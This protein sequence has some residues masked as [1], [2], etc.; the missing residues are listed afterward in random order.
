M[1]GT[2]IVLNSNDIIVK[3]KMIFYIISL[4]NTNLSQIVDHFA[5]K[6]TDLFK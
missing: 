6:L 3:L 1:K 2:M 4:K 5:I